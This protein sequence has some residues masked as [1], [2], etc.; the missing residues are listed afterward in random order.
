ME[1]GKDVEK[2]ETYDIMAK[3]SETKAKYL[4]QMAHARKFKDQKTK[5]G[6]KKAETEYKELENIENE[7]TALLGGDKS[8]Y[9]VVKTFFGRKSVN[10]NVKKAGEITAE[11]QAEADELVAAINRAASEL[12]DLYESLK[13]EANPQE[14]FLKI[15][16]AVLEKH[17]ANFATL[18]TSYEK[19]K[20]LADEYPVLITSIGRTQKPKIEGVIKLYDEK[21][22]KRSHVRFEES[23]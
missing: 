9:E 18:K 12:T 1:D 23:V 7:I 5:V 21:L 13:K 15:N 11:S 3:I 4:A 22:A 20:N 14:T 2:N 16:K 19:W 8:K 17:T 6:V 10:A